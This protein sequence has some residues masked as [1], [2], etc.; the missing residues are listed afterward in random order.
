MCR[1]ESRYTRPVLVVEDSDE[2]FDT[3]VEAANH[4][5]MTRAI[6]RAVSGSACLSM[7]A[8]SAGASLRLLPALILLDLNSYGVDGRDVLSTI[9]TDDRL[10]QI[11][12]VILTTSANAKD[13]VFCYSAGANAYHIKPV[14]HDQ[15]LL[16]LCS[17]MRYWLDVVSLQAMDLKTA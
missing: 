3:I 1:T 4:I 16:N 17:L 5:G 9:K 8:A 10:K 13:I 6:H 12:I 2:D 15:Y 14:R 11:P 7:L